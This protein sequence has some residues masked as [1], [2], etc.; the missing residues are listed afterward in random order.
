[1]A[2][3]MQVLVVPLPS[4]ESHTFVMVKVVQEMAARGHQVLVRMP[5]CPIVLSIQIMSWTSRL[6]LCNAQLLVGSVACELQEPMMHH[7]GC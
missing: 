5:S 7:S 1:M 3:C 4:A 6:P 2:S